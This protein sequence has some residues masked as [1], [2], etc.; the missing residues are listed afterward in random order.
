MKNMQECM[1]L[2]CKSKNCDVAVMHGS[3]CF[4]VQCLNDSTCE[5]VPANDED[6]DMQVAHMTTK[7]K[8]QISKHLNQHLILS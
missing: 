4:S 8:D 2:C 7:G 3:K 5:T 1:H 6:L